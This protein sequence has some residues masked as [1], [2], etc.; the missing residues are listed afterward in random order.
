MSEKVANG[1]LSGVVKVSGYFTSSVANSKVGKK[2]F[3][4]L[5][6]EI[7]LASL[8]G[9]GMSPTLFYFISSMPVVEYNLSSFYF[10]TSVYQ[11]V[12]SYIHTELFKNKFLTIELLLVYY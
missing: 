4:M 11:L 10:S 8:D 2:F 1:V 3:G 9:F 5:P 7:V 6:G 12:F